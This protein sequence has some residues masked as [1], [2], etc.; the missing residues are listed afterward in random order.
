[1][2]LSDT[3]EDSEDLDVR[4]KQKVPHYRQLKRQSS[5]SLSISDATDEDLSG[6]SDVERKART[7]PDGAARVIWT[8]SE[9]E[10]AG[11][12][13][14]RK[15]KASGGQARKRAYEATR[16]A[17]EI[18]AQNNPKSRD[19]DE[20]TTGVGRQ[21][22][23]IKKEKQP[24]YDD[25]PS[26]E[27]GMDHTMPDY[28]QQRRNRFDERAKRLRESGLALPPSYDNIDFS[29]IERIRT[30]KERPVL[31]HITPPAPYKD[32][33]LP[34]SLGVIPASIAQYLRPYQVD[35]A[36]FL[37]ELYVFQKGGVLGDDMGLGKTI[38]VIAFL[39]AAFGKT[40]DERDEKR[41]R[42]MRRRNLQYPRVLI[43]CPGSLMANWQDEL[44]RWVSRNM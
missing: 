14:A 21:R 33:E 15:F 19:K 8:D 36:A 22:R 23:K 17:K 40:G 1:M 20:G 41:M 28:V 7:N 11:A 4:P 18:D 29:D 32:V 38:Q 31:P 24:V 6:R 3:S 12:V 35:G 5:R 30:L 16:K 2:S 26:D 43:I 9:G 37:H 25:I 39:T 44:E 10:D 42:K 13:A 34:Y 27:Q